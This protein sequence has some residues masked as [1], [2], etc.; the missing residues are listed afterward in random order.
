MLQNV[1]VKAQ[2]PQTPGVDR[3][4]ALS[5][6]FYSGEV[7][8]YH[9]NGNIHEVGK[10]KDGSRVGKWTTYY[11]NGQK[12]KEGKYKVESVL[13]VIRPDGDHLFDVRSIEKGK[14][15][16]WDKN[17]LELDR[18][19]YF[20]E[21]FIMSL[22]GTYRYTYKSSKYNHRLKLNP[23]R[24][25]EW[26]TEVKGSRKVITEAGTWDLDEDTIKV[27]YFPAPSAL[28]D[29]IGEAIPASTIGQKM[30]RYVYN[31]KKNHLTGL[32]KNKFT[33]YRRTQDV[34]KQKPMEA[35][36]TRPAIRTGDLVDETAV[37]A[38]P[39]GAQSR[40]QGRQ[41][42]PGVS[43][44]QVNNRAGSGRP[45]SVFSG[46]GVSNTEKS[47]LLRPDNASN[48]LANRSKTQPE[49]ADLTQTEIDALESV[50]DPHE[51]PMVNIDGI[52]DENRGKVV[53][54]KGANRR[55]QKNQRDTNPVSLEPQANKSQS[56]KVVSSAPVVSGIPESKPM[57]STPPPVA[58]EKPIKQSPPAA[59][60]S[61]PKSAPQQTYTPPVSKPT[62]TPVVV[63][64]NK[65]NQTLGVGTSSPATAS[66][67]QSTST[68]SVAQSKHNNYPVLPGHQGSSNTSSQPSQT[69]PPTASRS[70]Q[71]VWTRKQATESTTTTTPADS[72]QRR[73]ASEA[74]NTKAGVPG[75]GN[76][77][78]SPI[79]VRTED[80]TGRIEEQQIQPVLMPGNADM[81]MKETNSSA[82]A[83][84]E[85]EV[86]VSQMDYP[87]ELIE[88]KKVD[89]LILEQI[90]GIAM[91]TFPEFTMSIPE[92]YG[93][94]LDKPAQT[95]NAFNIK[96]SPND[97]Y[98]NFE[99][100]FNNMNFK[101]SKVM[102]R[103]EK[104]LTLT[105]NGDRLELMHW[106]KHSTTPQKLKKSGKSSFSFQFNPATADW[107]P[108]PYYEDKD[109]IAAVEKYGND[110][111]IRLVKDT[112]TQN[113]LSMWNISQIF[114]TLEGKDDSGNIIRKEL[115]LHTPMEM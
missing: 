111:W 10:M 9:K 61:Q 76:P 69:S 108:F 14:W 29:E 1:Q 112:K 93:I 34:P 64:P 45:A 33:H 95:Q 105:S 72:R 36:Q 7:I 31:E 77:T 98:N 32:G 49:V 53:K 46:D 73:S 92:F 21:K 37:G 11:D 5:K 115:I 101:P 24:T 44:N 78:A 16:F 60:G 107:E 114:V 40:T 12:E 80:A 52:R 19:S 102:V 8:T 86:P 109:L 94:L 2:G 91:F 89:G 97:P 4:M 28:K 81:A 56:N 110:K 23:N 43:N 85:L 58:M 96:L 39:P 25:A 83:S 48:V 65:P 106:R 41:A 71:T 113:Y 90:N 18:D 88:Y 15:Y 103:Y 54:M 13:R 74:M 50:S 84:Q 51:D 27:K 6:E 20:H 63:R 42:P 47:S 68:N 22:A 100:M 75:S 26:V 38:K 104:T 30:V 87:E 99:F 70:N 3:I 79:N 62:F 67:N 66:V 35:K 55:K 57:I 59:S 17:G 82:S